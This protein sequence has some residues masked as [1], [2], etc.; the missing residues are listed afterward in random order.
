MIGSLYSVRGF[1]RSSLSGDHGFFVR[2]EV[3]MRRP[4]D[5]AGVTGSV[6][7]WLGLDYGRVYSRN[8]GV[9]EGALTGLALGAI[10]SPQRDQR[11]HTGHQAFVQAQFYAV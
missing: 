2:N 1:N 7:P 6:R 4:F 8:E 3:G 5:L 10:Q 9:P 11:R